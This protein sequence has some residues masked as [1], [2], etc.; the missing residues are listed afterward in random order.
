M[1]KAWLLDNKILV[2]ESGQ[3]IICDNCPCGNIGPP[4]SECECCQ[5]IIDNGFISM[6]IVADNITWNGLSTSFTYEGFILG[7]YIWSTTISGHVWYLI[8]TC[9]GTDPGC[10]TINAA[11]E[12]T[13]N[14]G[15]GSSIS[16]CPGSEIVTGSLG[17][18]PGNW[19]AT[20]VF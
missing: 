10:A 5:Y 4:P 1:A 14:A 8:L 16:G 13:V 17:G 3:V 15:S 12:A 18:G 6:L 7:N 9:S 20:I 2:N 11:P 19:T